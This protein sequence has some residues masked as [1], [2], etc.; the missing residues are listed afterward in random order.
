MCGKIVS[1]EKITLRLE[2]KRSNLLKIAEN[3]FILIGR[4]L[5]E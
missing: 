1:S 4:Y 2:M 5:N 3:N